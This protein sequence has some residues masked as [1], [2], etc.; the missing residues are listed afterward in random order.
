MINLANAYY[1]NGP[2]IQR[3]EIEYMLST[4]P[5]N[6]IKPRLWSEHR[7]ILGAEIYTVYFPMCREMLPNHRNPR[8]QF[9]YT[10]M[11]EDILRNFLGGGTDYPIAC[12]S[13]LPI[14]SHMLELIDRSAAAENVARSLGGSLHGRVLILPLT[15]GFFHGPAIPDTRVIEICRKCGEPITKGHKHAIFYEGDVRF[16]M[17]HKLCNII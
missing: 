3:Y 10:V 8:T 4:F 17:P 14:T 16:S 12:F 11:R 6:P 2:P 15:T 5:R 13:G 9:E 7:S 1:V